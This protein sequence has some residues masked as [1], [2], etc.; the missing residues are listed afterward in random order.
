M[1]TL[2]K[3]V[4]GKRV[5]KSANGI[6]DRYVWLSRMI[7][8]VPD[9]SGTVRSAYF[10]QGREADKSM[11]DPM[12]VFTQS[13]TEGVYA[14]GLNAGK[15]A[16]RDLSAYLTNDVN[17]RCPI[18][19]HANDQVYNDYL[20]RDATFG[21]NVVGLATD[22]GKAG[23]FLLWRHER[24][25]LP[26]AVLVDE[27]AHSR[28][29]L[30]LSDA[31]YVAKELGERVRS[32]AR[33]FL[34]PEG[35]PDPK[36]VDNLVKS[37]DPR[38]TYWARMEAHFQKFIADMP[39]HGLEALEAWRESAAREAQCAFRE[40]VGR[41]GESQRA[42]MAIAQVSDFFCANEQEDLQRKAAGKRG[43]RKKG[44]QI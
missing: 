16:W 22:P 27:D 35:N 6:A 25:N 39:S 13:N 41:L 17:L 18:L 44:D 42:L 4:D 3:V 38:P 15:A 23:K 5:A 20:N 29:N 36:D 31:E 2:D 28:L 11:G 24:V 37:I 34:P 21:L 33:K 30:A 1:A 26:A 9:Q 7:L 8:L 10:T 32:V 43:N 19:A 14:L 12:K 40:A